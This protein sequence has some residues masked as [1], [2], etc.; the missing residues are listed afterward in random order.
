MLI[1]AAD[2]VG[3]DGKEVTHII[4][5]SDRA[6]IPPQ[7]LASISVPVLILHGSE[8]KVVSPP[9]AVEEWRRFLSS[10]AFSSV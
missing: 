6:P 4:H 3:H 1:Q 5:W 7:Q 2:G 10:G 9:A 8:D